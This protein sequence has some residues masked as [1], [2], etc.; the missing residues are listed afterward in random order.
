[1]KEVNRGLRARNAV[2][3]L[4]LGLSVILTLVMPAQ[5]AA[6]TSGGANGFLISPVI[7]E[8]TVDKGQSQ[9]VQIAVQ[10]PTSL[11]TT[12]QA[13]VNDFVASSDES[14]TPR[15]LLNNNTPLP[16]NNFKALVSSIP[17]VS[18]APQE[19]KYINVTITVPANAHS[20]GYYGAVRFIP[21]N[22]GNQSNVGL[23][24]SVGTL[25]LVT[26]PGNLVEKLNLVQLSASHGSTPT[27]FFTSGNVSVLT[28]LNNVGDI[29]VQ[30]F[31]NVQ[32]KDMFGHVVASFQF[33]NTTPR[34]NILPESIRRYVNQLPKHSWLGRYT[35][36]EN[37]AYSQGSGNLIVASASFWYFPWW[38]I[39]VVI[40]LIIIIV[41][42]IWLLARRHGRRHH[43]HRTPHE[44]TSTT[45]SL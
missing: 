18:L 13:I 33:N 30:P 11:P 15:L 25:F 34:T 16:A 29:H 22:S 41:A 42:L 10:N 35:I 45:P 4:L 14:G 12:A 9:T 2:S 37:L 28:R 43:S 32:V 38:F 23:T 1:M 44:P 8:V 5:A 40:A 31:G 7:N 27:S 20:G 26:V 39:G 17:D 19:K 21:V 6:N 24:A 36:N 3:G